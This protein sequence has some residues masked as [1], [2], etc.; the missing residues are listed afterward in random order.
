MQPDQANPR[1]WGV[2]LKRTGT[3]V[4]AAL[5][6]VVFYVAVI[7]GQP[8]EDVVTVV[9]ARTDQPL[10]TA[11]ATS[12]LVL[13]ANALPTL[14]DVFPA[15][16]MYPLYGTSLTF[17]QAV[18]TD[19]PFEDAMGR[20]VTLTYAIEGHGDMTITSIYPARALSLMG[21]G[22]YVI[23]GTAG[24][25]LA[26]LRSI[27]MENGSSI[28]LHAQGRDALYVVT[29]PLLDASVLRQLTASLQLLTTP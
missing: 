29:T 6:M 10:L 21:K 24:Q 19:A 15:P 12:V 14:S 20:I 22:D 23:S 9:E 28:R 3:A 18:C 7:M 11:M 13:D 8:Q 25:T 2:I 4:L 27:R 16:L 5:L 26:G 1:Q 17:R